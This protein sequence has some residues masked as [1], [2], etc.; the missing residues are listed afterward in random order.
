[1]KRIGL[2]PARAGS[3]R[4]KSKNIRPLM[5]H[6]LIAYSIA[7]A[8][9]SGIFERVI[10][11]TD[12][13]LTKEIALYYGAEVPFLRPKELASSVSIDFE[14]ISHLFENLPD[15]YDTFAILRPTSPLRQAD[16]IQ[17]AAALLEARPEVDSIRAVQLCH[18]HPGKMWTIAGDL[19]QPFLPQGDMPV[20]WH[21]RQ[22]QDLPKVY[23][24][25]SSLEM[26]RSRVI[27]RDKSREGKIIAPFLTNEF[28]GMSIDYESD[29][30]LIEDA[31]RSG[32]STLPDPG[33]A[34]F[35]L[36]VTACS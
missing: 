13:E 29:W 24:Q 17:R 32:R 33:K 21:A 18:E 20:P 30:I 3:L 14:W 26:A 2:I 5:G 1:M 15:K 12:S 27:F 4:V 35:A 19:L 8:L 31:V 9:G 28:E 36:P 6:P 10:V 34:P 7:S 23:I 16:T 11:S 22:Y 25:N